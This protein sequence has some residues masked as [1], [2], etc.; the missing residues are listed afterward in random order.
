MSEPAQSLSV[1]SDVRRLI[2]QVETG[3][4]FDVDLTGHAYDVLR[5]AMNA[6]QARLG[7]SNLE[8]DVSARIENFA[9][10][11][12]STQMNCRMVVTDEMPELPEYDPSSVS[13]YDGIQDAGTDFSQVIQRSTIYGTLMTSVNITDLRAYFES[14]RKRHLVLYLGTDRNGDAKALDKML[15]AL[16]AILAAA[17]MDGGAIK[18]I[19]AAIKA[20]TLPPAAMKMVMQAIKLADLK[21]MPST[22]QTRARIARIQKEFAVLAAKALPALANMPAIAKLIATL[23]ATMLAPVRGDAKLSVTSLQTRTTAPRPDNDNKIRARPASTATAGTSFI[24]A[25]FVPALVALSRPQQ[26]A[27]ALRAIEA[28]VI[29][30][31]RVAL[32]A[33]PAVIKAA[34]AVVSRPPPLRLRCNQQKYHP[35]CHRPQP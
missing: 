34:A 18:E 17:G 22:P 11:S 29:P 30:I 21:A 13:I 19:I 33:A 27:A 7:N 10:K 23:R 35:P 2:K 9:T 16:P 20:G 8:Q 32:S 31:A 6:I 24:M 1:A 5:D 3:N 15:A 4:G 14:G 26:M 28:R 12:A 25:R